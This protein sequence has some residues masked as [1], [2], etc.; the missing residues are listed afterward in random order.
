MDS[1]HSWKTRFRKT[2]YW[3]NTRNGQN[4]ARRRL[5]WEAFETTS[6]N[7]ILCNFHTERWLHLV[8]IVHDNIS[9]TKT[10]HGPRKTLQIAQKKMNPFQVSPRKRVKTHARKNVRRDV[11][12]SWIWR[13]GEA[14]LWM[15]CFSVP[16]LKPRRMTCYLTCNLTCNLLTK[17]IT[18]SPTSTTILVDD[19]WAAPRKNWDQQIEHTKVFIVE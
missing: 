14:G 6:Y 19:Q 11:F 13:L 2:F 16:S 12:I 5:P 7:R 18:D 4:H 1:L 9:D 3:K 15:D 8:T 17:V 10:I